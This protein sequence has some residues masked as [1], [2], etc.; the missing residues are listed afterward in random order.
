MPDLR[1]RATRVREY[2]HHGALQAKHVVAMKSEVKIGC[3]K[4]RMRVWSGMLSLLTRSEK[5][6]TDLNGTARRPQAG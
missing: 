5:K 1:D 2:T 3:S 6:E 4:R